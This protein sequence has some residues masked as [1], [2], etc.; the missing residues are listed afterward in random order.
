MKAL[1]SRSVLTSAETRLGRFRIAEEDGEQTM[2]IL[3]RYLSPGSPEIALAQV[4][5]GTL[6]LR[7]H[8]IAQAEKILPAAIEAERRILP[9][10]TTL[11]NGIRTLAA[12]RVQQRAWSDAETLYREAIGIYERKFGAEHPDLAPLLREYA[13]VL[14]HRGARA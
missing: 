5:I 2:K 1:R 6:Y 13:V 11:A 10:E 3:T 12:L 4:T 7:E 8:K 9:N 14:K